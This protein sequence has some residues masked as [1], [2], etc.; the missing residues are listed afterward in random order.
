VL[1]DNC[2]ERM[3]CVIMFLMLV[4]R[5]LPMNPISAEAC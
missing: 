1:T 5:Q 4:Q 2:F 3:V